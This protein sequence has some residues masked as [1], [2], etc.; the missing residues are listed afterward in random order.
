MDESWPVAADGPVIV[1]RDRT[2]RIRP[3]RRLQESYLLV[4]RTI[5]DLTH[6]LRRSPTVPEIAASA[7]LREDEVLEAVDLFRSA[8]RSLNEPG[9][10]DVPIEVGQADAGFALVEER[11]LLRSILDSLILSGPGPRFEEG[12]TPGVRPP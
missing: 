5:D 12:S 4:L 9:D 6:E 1:L 10:D 2:W 8:P 7:G 3:S 11:L